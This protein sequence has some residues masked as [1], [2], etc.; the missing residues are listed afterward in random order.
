MNIFCVL[1]NSRDYGPDDVTLLREGIEEHL[2]IPHRFV[3]LSDVELDCERIPLIHNW[4]GWFA[5]MELFR[6]DIEGDFLYFDLD[7]VILGDMSDIC[8][9]DRLTVL[10]DFYRMNDPMRIGTG[11][12]FVPEE[13][14]ESIWNRWSVC[15]ESHRNDFKGGDQDFIRQ[16]WWS[17]QRWQK[18]LPGQVVSYKVD[19]QPTGIIPSDAR[20]MC[21][22]GRPKPRDIDIEC[23]FIAQGRVAYG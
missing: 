11:M 8:R 9:V 1:R 23:L 19:V 4:P 2:H 18:V 6:P 13:C 7:T 12:M 5:K 20:V 22:H 16:F 14:R 3:C 21:F 10:S 15:P 17:A